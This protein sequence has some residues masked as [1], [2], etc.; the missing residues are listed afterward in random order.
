MKLNR[1]FLFAKLSGVMLEM[2]RFHSSNSAIEKSWSVDHWLREK[3]VQCEFNIRHCFT[4]LIITFGVK[5]FLY[6]FVRIIERLMEV[7]LKEV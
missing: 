1:I 3:R 7:N 6:P 2:I 5:I 4:D